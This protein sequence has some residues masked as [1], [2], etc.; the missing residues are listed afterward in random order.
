MKNPENIKILMLASSGKSSRIVYN[1]LKKD[2]PKLEI[3]IEQPP[4]KW[5]MVKNRAKKLGW[6]TVFGQLVF[7]IFTV[8]W[9]DFRGKKRLFKIFEKYELDD[10]PIP[11]NKIFRVPSV[12]SPEA[13]SKIKNAAA[14][15]ILVNG[16]RIISK[17]TLASTDTKFINTHLGITPNYRGVHGGYW[18]LA[19]N[20]RKNFGATVHLVDSGVDT[21]G[22]LKRVFAEPTDRDNFSTYPTLQ[23]AA[24]LPEIKNALLEV[25]NHSENVLSPPDGVSQLWYHPT[26]FQYL[27]NRIFKGVR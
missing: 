14:D 21:G 7:Q 18:A 5:K 16:T 6:P 3:I 20:D 1:F 2:F 27:K 24:A 17:K 23:L 26:I 22:I 10:S 8:R 9:T 12:N 4:G 11:E 15:V 25:A 13:I 19:K